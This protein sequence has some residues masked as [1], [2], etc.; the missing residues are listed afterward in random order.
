[1]ALGGIP[2]PPPYPR[3]YYSISAG[4]RFAVQVERRHNLSIQQGCFLWAAGLLIP[5]VF[6]LP[7]NI[8]NLN[9]NKN[10]LPQRLFLPSESSFYCPYLFIFDKIES[11]YTPSRSSNVGLGK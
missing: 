5:A 6:L 2:N 4:V 11:T 3:R 10:T 9:K 8:R 7:S 1:M